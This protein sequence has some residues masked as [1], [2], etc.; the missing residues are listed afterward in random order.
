[1]SAFVN[2]LINNAGRQL[3]TLPTWMQVTSLTYYF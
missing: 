2:C 1:M 3:E